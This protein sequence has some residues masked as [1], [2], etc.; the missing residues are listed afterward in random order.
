VK[1]APRIANFLTRVGRELQAVAWCCP[2]TL[3]N[4]QAK[5]AVQ[6]QVPPPFYIFKSNGK[7]SLPFDLEIKM[8]PE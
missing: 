4:T 6:N 7:K 8:K 5:R 3:P 2:P 1:V